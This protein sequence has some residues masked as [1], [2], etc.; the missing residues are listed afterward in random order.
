M[1]RVEAKK[2]TFFSIAD[3]NSSRFQPG[4]LAWVV[5]D[6]SAQTFELLWEIVGAWKC[7]FYVTDEYKAYPN[8]IL[9]GESPN[10]FSQE[11]RGTEA[12]SL[13]QSLSYSPLP[14]ERG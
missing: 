7:F 10:P 3:G 9:D 4:L 5:G 14:R 13:F 11:R 8:S 12:S 6:H 2:I 1:R